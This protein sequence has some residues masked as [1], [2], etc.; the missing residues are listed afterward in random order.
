MVSVN[1]VD[2]ALNDIPALQGSYAVQYSL[3]TSQDLKVGQLGKF[4]LPVGEYLYLGSAHGPGGLRARISRH[5]THLPAKRHWHI[6]RLHAVSHAHSFYYLLGT[7]DSFKTEFHDSEMSIECIWS[8]V[9]A[10]L[11]DAN[12]PAPGFGSSDCRAGCPAHLVAFHRGT[13][14]RADTKLIKMHLAQA[15]NVQIEEIVYRRIT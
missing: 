2:I 3:P 9:L 15:V 12:I 1:R 7:A 14:P 11:P 10:D 4:H 8:Q 5:L 13:K 6:D